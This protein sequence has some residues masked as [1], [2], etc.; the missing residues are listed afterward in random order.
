[1]QAYDWIEGLRDPQ[2]AN[3]RSVNEIQIRLILFYSNFLSSSKNADAIMSPGDGFCEII[4]ICF[5]KSTGNP[6]ANV[7]EAYRMYQRCREVV[8]SNVVP[9]LHN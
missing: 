3:K 1:M 9:I 5:I 6:R 7:T 2:I 8:Q 4:G